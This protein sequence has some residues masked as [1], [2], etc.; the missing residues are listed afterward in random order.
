MCVVCCV[1]R[2]W[3]CVIV[4]LILSGVVGKLVAGISG[5]VLGMFVLCWDTRIVWCRCWGCCLCVGVDIEGAIMA[6]NVACH[7]GSCS[8]HSSCTYKFLS[9]TH[10]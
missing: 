4:C 8:C 5:T 3:G 2:M 1:G 9:H 10:A 6:V 7:S